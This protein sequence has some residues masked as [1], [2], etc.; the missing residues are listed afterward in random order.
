MRSLFIWIVAEAALVQVYA[1]V[2]LFTVLLYS[3]DYYSFA[4]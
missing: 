2:L 1:A 3:R 4:E